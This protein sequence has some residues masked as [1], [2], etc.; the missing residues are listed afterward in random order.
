MWALTKPVMPVKQKFLILS[1]EIIAF[2]LAKVSRWQ[3][4]LICWFRGYA[5]FTHRYQ[6]SFGSG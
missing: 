6:G 1:L 5:T 4:I 3:A 2:L